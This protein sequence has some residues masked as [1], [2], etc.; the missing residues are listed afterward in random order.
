MSTFGYYYFI[1][2]AN[3]VLIAS[4][5]ELAASHVVIDVDFLTFKLNIV[6][7]NI[8]LI[9]FLTIL[10]LFIPMLKIKRSKPVKIIKTKE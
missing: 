9:L 7:I 6:N 3:D 2:L 5:K 1:D 4:L 8:V 10:S